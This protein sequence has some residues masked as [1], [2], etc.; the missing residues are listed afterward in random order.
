M[1]KGGGQQQPPSQDTSMNA[2][3]ISIGVVALAIVVWFIWR[4]YII[5]F[6]YKLKLYQALFMSNFTDQLDS[7]IQYLYVVEAG[8]VTFDEMLAVTERVGSFIAIPYII[9]LI[10]FAIIL[11]FTNTGLRFRKKY[12]MK[13]LRLQEYINWPQIAPVAK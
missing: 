5:L 3:W 13:D 7:T 10:L 11:Y 12:S 6:V 9:L 8:G 4:E 2:I 1:S